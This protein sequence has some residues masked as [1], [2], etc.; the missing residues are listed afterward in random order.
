VCP[1][2]S[3]GRKLLLLC[4]SKRLSP[5]SC[6]RFEKGSTVFVEMKKEGEKNDEK[7]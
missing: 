1:L 2:R 7:K 4:E 6:G 5:L 3:I